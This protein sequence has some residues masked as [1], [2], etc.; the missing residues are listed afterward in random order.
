MIEISKDKLLHYFP[1]RIQNQQALKNETVQDAISHIAQLLWN[2]LNDSEHTKR[3]NA[4]LEV[5]LVDLRAEIHQWK[6]KLQDMRET[7]SDKIKKRFQEREERF[8]KV[9]RDHLD[10]E[11]RK[12]YP[13]GDCSWNLADDPE[14]F[15]EDYEAV[16]EEFKD[17][18]EEEQRILSEYQAKMERISNVKLRNIEPFTKQDMQQVPGEVKAVVRLLIQEKDE[19]E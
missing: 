5:K 1:Y 15:K 3:I 12:M 18:N 14:K 8:K 16:E 17:I 7:P 13:R 11:T 6:Q 9:A 2:F 10:K 4:D 19:E